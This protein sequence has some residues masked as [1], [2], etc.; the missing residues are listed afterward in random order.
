LSNNKIEKFDSIQTL[1]DATQLAE[2]ALDGNPIA[3]ITN[4]QESCLKMCP[5]LKHLD[6]TK[7]TPEMRD[8]KKGADSTGVSPDK[9][10]N[11]STDVT[12]DKTTSSVPTGAPNASGANGDD[13]SPTD[14]LE[15]ISQEWKHEMER[16]V[17]L[18]LNGYKRR[19]ESRNECLVQ[20]GHAEIEGDTML[21]IYGNALEVL[22]NAE[23]QKTVEQISF[24]YVRFDNIVSHSNLGKLRKFI[25]LKKLMFSDNNIHSF[26]QISKLEC[27]QSLNNLSIENNDVSKTILCRT[28]IVYR[29][30]NVVDISGL[31]VTD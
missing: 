14:L 20:S 28:F 27:L 30:P 4:Y 1:K 13:I 3:S 18:G 6:L 2:L 17:T 19:K 23:F 25:R 10:E 5:N 7:V 21:F 24:Q 11:V 9:G 16:I 31:P 22:N 12:P 29:F 8:N 26:I 15:V